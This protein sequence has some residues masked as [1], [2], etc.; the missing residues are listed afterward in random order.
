M[1][2]MHDTLEYFKKES[3][4]RKYHHNDLTFS[5][6]YA[7]TENFL[8]SLSHDEVVHGKG[9]LLSKMPGDAWQKQA[10]L[11]LLLGYMFA[12]PG[13]KLLFM[14]SE[15]GQGTEWNHEGSLDWY[16][17]DYAHHA[18]IKKWV[19]DLNALYRNEPALSYDD[20]TG[21]GFH[22]I[23]GGDVQQSVISF[24]RLGPRKD[25]AMIFVINFTP[26]PR[27]QYR[28]GIPQPGI[29]REVINSDAACYGGSNMGN[30]GSR[31]GVPVP[32]HGFY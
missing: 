31:P 24:M 30:S 5:F 1:G 18:G 22:W 15:F 12:H 6:L 11:R 28:V 8:L 26:V 20:F 19:I 25:D 23:D 4:H 13:K 17:L 16:V 21:K 3:V 32:Y 10:N 29:W 2:W 27:Y 7:F 9:S 14:G